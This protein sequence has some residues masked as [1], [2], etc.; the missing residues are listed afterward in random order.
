[1]NERAT[2]LRNVFIS[3]SLATNEDWNKELKCTGYISNVQ[4]VFQKMLVQACGMSSAH[5]NKKKKG[6]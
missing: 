5:Q 2:F 3:F 1:L 4:G 6:F